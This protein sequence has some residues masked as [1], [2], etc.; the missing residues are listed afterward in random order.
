MFDKLNVDI[1]GF[2]QSLEENSETK[3]EV[4]HGCFLDVLYNSL[5]TLLFYGLLSELLTTYLNYN[6]IIL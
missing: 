1:R 5:L 2:L 4:S 3:P 6:F